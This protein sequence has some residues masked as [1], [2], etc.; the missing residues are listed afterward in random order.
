MKRVFQMLCN[1][2]LTILVILLFSFTILNFLSAPGKSGLFGFKG[3]TVLSNSM[4]PTFKAGDYIIDRVTPY[5]DLAIDDVISYRADNNIIVTHRII[6]K[7]GQE[8]I[9]QGDQNNQPD[10]MTITKE[11]YIGTYLFTIP[12]LGQ[13]TNLLSGPLLLIIF[14]FGIAFLFLFLYVKR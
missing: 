14:A 4:T 11:N 3:Y 5:Q 10:A 2:L 1:S 8:F 13:L 12:L 7:T 9:V 6:K